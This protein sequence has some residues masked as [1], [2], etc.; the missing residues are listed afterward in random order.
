MRRLPPHPP[1]LCGPN[2]QPLGTHETK[3]AA[4]VD[5]LTEN[6]GTLCNL[7]RNETHQL[8]LKASHL[9]FLLFFKITG[10]KMT[11]QNVKIRMLLGMKSKLGIGG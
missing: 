10:M 3:M 1:D 5:D 4:A 6:L 2:T 8:C 9:S 11:I 7:A